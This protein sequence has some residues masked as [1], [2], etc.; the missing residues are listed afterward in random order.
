VHHLPTRLL[1][2]FERDEVSRRREARFFR[3]L[4]LGGVQRILTRLEL[5]FGNRPDAVVFAGPERATG[6]DEK[7]LKRP[8]SQTVE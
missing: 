5:A 8:I 7:Y 6:M 4:T 3:E 1:E 2:R